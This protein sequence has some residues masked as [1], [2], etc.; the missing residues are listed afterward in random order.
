MMKKIIL[1]SAM[2]I[3]LSFL[4]SCEE[5]EKGPVLKQEDIQNPASIQSLNGNSFVLKQEN[6]DEAMTTFTWNEAQFGIDLPITYTLQITPAGSGF[7]SRVANVISTGNDSVSVTQG[8]MN[9]KLFLTLGMLPGQSHNVDVRV[10]G[11]VTEKIDTVYSDATTLAVTPYQVMY[12]MLFVPGDY[13]GW[14]ASDSST[15]IY[16][17][18]D[19]G[20]YSGYLYF[21]DALG[22]DPDF[23]TGF[24]LL[25]VPGWEADNTIGD[26][27]GSGTS[28]TLQIGNWGGNNIMVSG[29]PGYYYLHADLN[30]KTYSYTRTEWGMIGSAAGGWGDG[31]DIFMTYQEDQQVWTATAD[32]AAGE[33]KFRANGKWNIEYGDNDG[34]GTLEMGGANI[35]VEEAGTYEV[36]LNLSNPPYRYTLEMQ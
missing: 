5:E 3:G 10:R 18:K 32:L 35:V 17:P 36:T 8:E 26:P 22:D 7:E 33:M 30:N 21:N 20:V 15:V 31:D 16:S 29:D 4:I 6:Q 23:I 9:N 13:Q 12:P 27:E 1:I 14:N 2:L 34:N 28:G 25:K 24:K 11:I 19:N